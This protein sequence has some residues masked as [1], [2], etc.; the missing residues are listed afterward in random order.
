MKNFFRRIGTLVSN[1]FSNAR[2]SASDRISRTETYIAERYRSCEAKYLAL[3]TK[4]RNRVFVLALSSILILDYLMICFL[5]DRNPINIF[6]SIPVLDMR[7][8]ISVWLPSPDSAE[9]LCEKRRIQK[10]DNTAE[11]IKRLTR[12]VIEGSHFENTRALTPIE[13]NVRTVWIFDGTCAVDMRLD[14]ID[15][16]APFVAGSEAKFR[17]ALT[18]TIMHNVKG[19]TKVIVLENGIPGKDIWESAAAERA[20]M[21]Q[22]GQTPSNTSTAAPDM[23]R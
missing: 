13:G 6:P 14:P 20:A 9:P 15:T 18:R 12:L 22:S 17:D 5:V 3:E 1:A 11:Y 16:D 2:K 8:E 10:S 19:I 7:S 23:N 21:L 4:K